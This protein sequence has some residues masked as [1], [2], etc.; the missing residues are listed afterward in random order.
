MG[1]SYAHG[2]AAG[3]LATLAGFLLG[4]AFG[5]AAL[6][7]TLRRRRRPPARRAALALV[8]T[9]AGGALTVAMLR[10]RGVS[11]IYGA[12]DARMLAAYRP[13]QVPPDLVPS[14]FLLL[15]GDL[16]CHVAPPDDDYHVTRGLPATLEL[17]RAEGLDFVNLTPHLW[18][19]L[20]KQPG[21]VG[22]ILEGHRRLAVEL[23]HADTKGLLVTAGAESTDDDW[24]HVGM[25]FGDYEAA[26]GAVTDDEVDGRLGDFFQRFVDGGGVLTLHHPL[27]QPRGLAARA[28]G[29]D[30]SWRPFTSPGAAAP[31]QIA[32]ADRVASGVEAYNLGVSE[33]RDWLSFGDREV[34]VR[35]VLARLDRE[36]VARGRRLTPVAGTDSHGDFLRPVLFV[37]ARERSIAAVREAI[38][39]GRTCVRDGAACTLEAR[40]PG[41]TWAPV[42]ASL[43]SVDE[44]ELRVMG[45]DAAVLVNGVET[46]RP[47]R[48]TAAVVRTPRGRCSLIRAVVGGGYSAPVY[49]NCPF[50]RLP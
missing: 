11:A 46:V 37:L 40:A 48:A 1:L 6:L 47:A 31:H 45:G 30:I 15:A 28:F 32:V 8:L 41:G 50:A 2:I 29:V 5:A 13:P 44:V 3:V 9:L 24:G 38:V 27:V 36:I 16:H 22:H 19:P 21:Y 43:E 49:A 33:M 23:A 12:I 4:A 10:A 39:E 34:S 20:L 35:D 17:A 7:A 42:G 14:P 26:L 18:T 25:A